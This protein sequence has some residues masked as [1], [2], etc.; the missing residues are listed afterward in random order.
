M[1]SL[2]AAWAFMM[3]RAEPGY[4]ISILLFLVVSA[5]MLVMARLARARADAAAFSEAIVGSPDDA[6]VT[7]DLDGNIRSWNASAECIFG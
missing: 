4:D 7:K 3:P 6:I 1:S 5:V 2:V